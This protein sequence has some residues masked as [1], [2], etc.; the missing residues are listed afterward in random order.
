MSMSLSENSTTQKVDDPYLPKWLC[1]LMRMAIASCFVA[2]I[3]EPMLSALEK[4]LCLVQEGQKRSFGNHMT[5]VFLLYKSLRSTVLPHCSH[6]SHY[7][8]LCTLPKTGKFAFSLLLF[9]LQLALL[10]ISVHNE[11]NSPRKRSR[12]HFHVSTLLI[13]AIIL[14]FALSILIPI[15]PDVLA[16]TNVPHLMH[17]GRAPPIFLI[18]LVL[19]LLLATGA[20][21]GLR[22]WLTSCSN[23]WRNQR[24]ALTRSWPGCIDPDVSCASVSGYAASV[25]S[26]RTPQSTDHQSSPISSLSESPNR[27]T[28][29]AISSTSSSP[30]R[31]AFRPSVLTW[32]PQSRNTPWAPSFSTEPRVTGNIAS[33]VSDSDDASLITSVSQLRASPQLRTTRSTSSKVSKS[34]SGQGIRHRHR[35]RKGLLRFCLSFLFGRL[36]SWKDVLDELTSLFNALLVG[37]IIYGICRLFLTVTDLV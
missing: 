18:L 23:D 2:L 15:I 12:S 19:G 14:L 13:D 5:Q 25:S 35:K 24:R 31:S 20:I 37:V 28:R 7:V 27:I 10:I 22:A 6:L 33:D 4:Q 17:H 29:T 30:P 34:R 26:H 21:L 1:L 16:Q 32:P 9:A 3:S 8:I 36:D 11:S